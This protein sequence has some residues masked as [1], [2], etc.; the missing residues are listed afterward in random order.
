MQQI[1]WQEA[2]KY[3]FSMFI[4]FFLIGIFIAFL[5]LMDAEFMEGDGY[6]FFG[7]VGL[8]LAISVSYG[9]AYKLIADSV[10]RGNNDS[11]YTDMMT[12]KKEIRC[13]ERVN[14]DY[15]ISGFIKFLISWAPIIA[16]SIL[17][18]VIYIVNK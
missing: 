1:S 7:F 4:F 13:A 12:E 10:I 8:I 15:S 14:R 9:A 3:G 6:G 11:D 16:L 5:L 2:I 17:F 18:F